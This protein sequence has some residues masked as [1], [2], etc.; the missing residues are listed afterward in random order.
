MSKFHSLE[1][2]S[3]KQETSD[4]ISI[5]FKIP[6]ELQEEYHYKQGQYLTL[7]A[8]IGDLDVRRAYSLCSSPVTGEMPA[9]TCKRVDGGKMS[10]YLANE[11]KPGMV[12]NV[13]PPQGR[14]FTEM[15]AAHQK[16]Y[17]LIGGGSG[18]T[19]LISIIKTVLIKE[20]NSICTLIYGNRNLASIIFKTE[21]DALAAANPGRLTLVYSLDTA[22]AGWTGVTGLLTADKIS[23]LIKEALGTITNR[24]YFLCGPEGLMTQART[25]FNQLN[26]PSANVHIEFFA[27]PVAD[28]KV[29]PVKEEPVLDFEGSKVFVTLD[30]KEREILIKDN[31]LS[32]LHAAIKAGMDAPFSCEAGICSTCMA[33]VTE[34]SVKMDENN[35][36]SDEEVAKG[37]VLTCQAHPTSKIVR[38]EYY[39]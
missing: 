29:E 23:S 21:L 1:V 30:G 4:A 18:I 36:L 31:K 3:V 6:A 12:M 33:K 5:S 26:L 34:G 22:D 11:I 37:Y 14:F 32:I 24:E 25:A 16:H 7:Q 2:A 15:D 39:D 28:K 17:I 38:L 13:M 35:I 10:N 9:V 20:P 8:I 27:A 19:P